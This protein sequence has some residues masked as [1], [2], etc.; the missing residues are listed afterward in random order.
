MP[1]IDWNAVDPARLIAALGDDESAL[2]RRAFEIAIAAAR[3]DERLLDHV[4]VA[5]TV[6]LAWQ[7]A[8]PPREVLERLFTRAPSDERWARD[9]SADALGLP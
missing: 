4:A 3:E 8:L 5:A 9:L 1:R 2:A 7:T 6:F